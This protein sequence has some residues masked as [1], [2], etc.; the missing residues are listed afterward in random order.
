MSELALPDTAELVIKTFWFIVAIVAGVLVATW[1]LYFA[2][3]ELVRAIRRG[4]S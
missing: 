2:A 4:R 1:L 3:R